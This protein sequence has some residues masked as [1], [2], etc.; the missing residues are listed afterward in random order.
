MKLVTFL[1]VL[2]RRWLIIVVAT[3]AGLMVAAG[4]TALTTPQYTATADVYF[5]LPS[6]SSGTDLS[7][8]SVFAQGQVASYAA[9][10]TSSRVL[11]PV[12]Q[13]LGLSL[14]A[15]QLA[16]TLAV[17]VVQGTVVVEVAA[18]DPRPG[19]AAAVANAVA[20]TLGET[21]T[22]LSP[23]N[24]EGK[25]SIDANVVTPASAPGSPTSPKT[26]RDLVAGVLGGLMIGIFL[27]VVREL[28]DTRIR[29]A[30]D[31]EA[32]IGLPVV[33]RLRSSRE[34]AKH[35]LAM[36]DHRHGAIS[37]SFRR[38]RTSVSF[39]EL[40]NPP[41]ILAISSAV[42][43]EGKSTIATNLAVALGE[44]GERVLLIDG[45]LRDPAVGDLLGL[46]ASAGL[47]TALTGR[48]SLDDVIQPW[49]GGLIDVI[50]SG[51]LTPN[52]SE[53]LGSAAMARLLDGVRRRYD[54]ILVDTAPL[55]PVTDTAV[56]ASQV[57]GV[58]LVARCGKVARRQLVDALNALQTVSARIFGIVLNGAPGSPPRRHS[59]GPVSDTSPIPALTPLPGPTVSMAQG[60][61]R[62][63][64]GQQSEAPPA[65][66]FQAVP[67][68]ADELSK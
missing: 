17:S 52:P 23:R 1:G 30:S 25:A 13:K 10:A 39:L 36:R 11:D 34:I 14:S 28:L 4:S 58:L 29:D 31:V 15:N 68:A 3:A 44:Q 16:Q 6:G 20:T 12:V 9:L 54:V 19:Q 24:A 33:G 37:E 18:T 41:L 49:G 65:R 32:L 55:V 47:T 26:S 46:G 53:L 40:D 61:R 35:P 2:R 57:S 42:A 45:D 43:G 48:A 63:T 21:V 67:R 5:F 50:T 60:R 7:Q 66:Q 62:S 8:G 27:S 22:A 64:G 38:L 59:V 51:E 56:L